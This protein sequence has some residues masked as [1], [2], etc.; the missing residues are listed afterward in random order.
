MR[1]ALMPTSVP[2][3]SSCAGVRLHDGK[4]I[5]RHQSNRAVAQGGGLGGMLPHRMRAMALRDALHQRCALDASVSDTVISVAPTRT[6]RWVQQRA[7]LAGTMLAGT[8]LLTALP[9]TP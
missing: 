5:A 2:P 9:T 3:V 6:R 1:A 8:I 4:G 7:L